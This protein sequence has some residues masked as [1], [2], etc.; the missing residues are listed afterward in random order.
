MDPK[1]AAFAMREWIRPKQ[2]VAMHYGMN[3]QA[4]GTLPQ[5]LQEMGSMADRVV[6]LKPGEKM[7]F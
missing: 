6:P 3:P 2:V 7:E 5:F 1:D 4:Y